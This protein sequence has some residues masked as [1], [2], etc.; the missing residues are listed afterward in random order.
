M[1]PTA[2]A[3]YGSTNTGDKAADTL[4]AVVNTIKKSV[5]GPED[6]Y[7]ALIGTLQGLFAGGFGVLGYKNSIK[8]MDRQGRRMQ[9]MQ[10]LDAKAGTLPKGSQQR[11][12]LKQ[13]RDNL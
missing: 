7:K 1:S 10:A 11:A 2:K 5:V 8:G 9:L 13:M 4:G 12:V 6:E 3:M